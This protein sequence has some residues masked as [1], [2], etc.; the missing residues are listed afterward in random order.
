[1]SM[2]MSLQGIS[3][4]EADSKSPTVRR[5]LAMPK[6][7]AASQPQQSGARPGTPLSNVEILTRRRQGSTASDT[8]LLC[9]FDNTLTDCDAGERLVPHDKVL[10][11]G[12]S[13]MTGPL[14][15]DAYLCSMH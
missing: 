6:A 13:M 8:L 4:A 9:D 2:W 11:A 10:Q 7:P 3:L 15:F 14:C 1:M 12:C 5:R